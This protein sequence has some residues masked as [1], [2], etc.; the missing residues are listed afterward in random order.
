MRWELF[1]P[2]AITYWIGPEGLAFAT[3]T[4]GASIG[5]SAAGK[6]GAVLGDLL[7]FLGGD[8]EKLRERYEITIPSRNEGI[9]IVAKPRS[10]GVAKNVTRLEM[11]VG[12]DLWSVKR[13]VIEE[14]NGDRSVIAFESPKR[15]VPVDAATM[16]PTK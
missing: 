6:F 9:V 15:D 3:A 13:V 8:L 7:I 1:A 16:K 12:P 2:D 4:G 5:R 14:S 10:E 11:S